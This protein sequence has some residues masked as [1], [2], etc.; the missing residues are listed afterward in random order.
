MLAFTITRELSAAC[1]SNSK[2]ELPDG[3]RI[4]TCV[5]EMRRPGKIREERVFLMNDMNG[6]M[7]KSEK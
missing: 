5:L 3:H 1:L 7:T 2:G 6:I 4:V